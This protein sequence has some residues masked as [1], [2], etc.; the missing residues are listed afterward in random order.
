MKKNSG[1]FDRIARIVVGG[2]LIGLAATGQIGL[3]GYIGIIPLVTGLVGWCPL[4]IPLGIN[5]CCKS[6][7]CCVRPEKKAE[8]Q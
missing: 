6:N 2:I 5:T 1:G 4:Y 8:G 7:S 3:W